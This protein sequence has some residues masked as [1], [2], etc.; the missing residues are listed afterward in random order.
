MKPRHH[1]RDYQRQ[2]G[3]VTLAIGILLL[4]LITT[5]TLFGARI[6]VQEQRISANDYRAKEAFA[7]AEAALS[8]GLEYLKANR[9]YI[10]SEKA[11]GWLDPDDE[12]WVEVDCGPPKPSGDEGKL[13]DAVAPALTRQG[14]TGEI[15]TVFFYGEYEELDLEGEPELQ[16]QPVFDLTN[17]FSATDPPEL[18][19]GAT[20]TV[21]YA[22]CAKAE[23]DDWSDPCSSD[24]V[25]AEDIAVLIFGNGT[26]PDTTGRA[27]VRQLIA[28][29]GVIPGNVL[30]PLTAAGT[31]NGS[32][33]FDVVVNPD[34]GGPGVPISAWS[35]HDLELTGSA[36][37]CQVDEYFS[38][39]LEE[40]Y[41]DQTPKT[42][43]RVCDNC[44]CPPSDALTDT[45]GSVYD[46][47]IDIVDIDTNTG[48][49]PDA[50]NFPDDVFEYVFGV[51]QS[52]YQE[53]KENAEEI[54]DCAGLNGD[55]RGMYWI[56]GPC[57][58]NNTVGHPEHPVILVTESS[59]DIQGGGEVFGLAYAFSYPAEGIAGGDITLRGGTRFYGAIVSDH[60]I[61]M[62][63]GT[64]QLIYSDELLS[65]VLTEADFK[66]FARVPGTWADHTD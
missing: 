3:I 56:T 9:S 7:A 49:T 12:K 61:D 41:P 40:V 22:L 42:D 31:V 29:F 28:T 51:P 44:S 5:V 38:T 18:D 1:Y 8:D 14:A 2:G 21:D 27:T 55:A 11:D 63:N 52:D 16:L 65:K 64:F 50:T 59:I 20:Y 46:E 36:T 30:P 6:Q 15:G 57:T 62:G 4:V 32:G 60:E 19:N 25:G 33:T 58:I 26:S 48:P 47:G 45:E 39:G 13:C 34:G 10:R 66:T 43:F 54:A 17:S 35:N 23:G 24:A 37:M 53:V